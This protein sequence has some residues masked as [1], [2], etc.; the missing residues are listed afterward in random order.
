M[1]SNGLRPWHGCLAHNRDHCPECRSCGCFD[2]AAPWRASATTTTEE[3]VMSSYACAECGTTTATTYVVTTLDPSDPQDTTTEV[4]RACDDTLARPD[5]FASLIETLARFREHATDIDA[6][7]A[8]FDTVE[9]DT[10]DPYTLEALTWLA[11]ADELRIALG[12][13]HPDQ[14][15]DDVDTE[16]SASRQ[17]YIETGRYLRV[18][19][20]ES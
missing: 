2:I 3:R 12:L 6:D 1:S 14:E 15:N 16:S 10:D 11:A 7:I 19:E 4:C 17:H 9:G 13:P 5:R 8:D 18:G 20:A